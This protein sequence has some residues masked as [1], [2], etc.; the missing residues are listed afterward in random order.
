MRREVLIEH[1]EELHQSRGNILG[2]RVVPAEWRRGAKATEE[3]GAQGAGER[4]AGCC[5]THA[6]ESSRNGVQLGIVE[7]VELAV[8]V[9]QDSALLGQ[10]AATVIADGVM[11]KIVKHLQRQKETRRMHVCVPVKD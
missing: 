8:G 5:L 2:Q 4:T 11:A 7:L 6:Q 9:D 3:P 10:L 1:I